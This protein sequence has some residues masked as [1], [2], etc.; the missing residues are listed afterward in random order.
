MKLTPEKRVAFAMPTPATNHNC[1][2]EVLVHTE[3]STGPPQ[4][5]TCASLGLGRFS[6]AIDAE[7]KSTLPDG[8]HEAHDEGVWNC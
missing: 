2:S 7:E 3:G 6:C 4:D 8:S 1:R 5:S